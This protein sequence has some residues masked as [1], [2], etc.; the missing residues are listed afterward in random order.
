MTSTNRKF[1]PIWFLWV[2]TIREPAPF[3]PCTCSVSRVSFALLRKIC[4]L[5][6]ATE[7]SSSFIFKPYSWSAVIAV[8]VVRVPAGVG[9]A[10]GA[11]GVALTG[12]GFAGAGAAR[13]EGAATG[14]VTAAVSAANAETHNSAETQNM[15]GQGNRVGMWLFIFLLQTAYNSGALYC[16]SN[17]RRNGF[18]LFRAHGR[19]WTPLS[20]CSF[21]LLDLAEA[22]PWDARPRRWIQNPA[23]TLAGQVWRPSS[24]CQIRLHRWSQWLQSRGRCAG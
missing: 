14:A 22:E 19:S 23:S 11:P 17:R 8:A 9:L 10:A 5:S 18:I 16:C 6:S 4:S 2:I 1:A 20:I 24:G 12:F 13:V 3:P 21:S 7:S 15:P